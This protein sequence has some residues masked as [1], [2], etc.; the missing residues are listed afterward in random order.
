MFF[1]KLTFVVCLLNSFMLCAQTSSWEIVEAMGR[2]VNLG[3]TFSAPVEG[4]WAPIVH[5]QYFI[6]VAEAGFSNVRIPADFFGSRTDGDTTVWSSSVNT[7][8]QYD[9]SVADFSVSSV[10]LDRIENVIDWSLNQG[11]YTVLDFHGA[12][13]KS[14]FLETFNILS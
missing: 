3:N 5:E 12:E 4:N 8:D 13:L 11:L 7:A 2:G 10:Y 6:D 1:N 9:G 14:E